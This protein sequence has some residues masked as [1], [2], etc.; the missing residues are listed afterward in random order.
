MCCVASHPKSRPITGTVFLKD[1]MKIVFRVVNGK[2]EGVVVPMDE[3]IS[4]NDLD[5]VEI[6]TT[7]QLISK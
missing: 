3:Y 5:N 6:K 1:G 7:K 4:V 2:S